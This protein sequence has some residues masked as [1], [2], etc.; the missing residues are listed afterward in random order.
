M[1][2][3]ER[4]WEQN[5]AKSTHNP[6]VAGSKPDEAGIGQEFEAIEPPPLSG[7]GLPDPDSLVGIAMRFQIAQKLHAVSDRHEPPDSINDRA[8]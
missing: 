1:L 3:W 5:T 2:R 6:E 4:I 8:L 7:F